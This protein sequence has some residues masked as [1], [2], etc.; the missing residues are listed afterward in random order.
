MIKPITIKNKNVVIVDDIISTGHTV[1]EAAKQAKKL[2]AKTI[3]AIC[4]HGLFVEK[5]IEKLKRAGVSKII[6][7]NTIKHKTNEIDVSPLLVDELRK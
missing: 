7:T 1:V 3:S 6:S 4:V 2:G 5:A